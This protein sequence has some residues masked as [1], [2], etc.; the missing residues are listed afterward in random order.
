M[1]RAVASQ[2]AWPEP[3]FRINYGK[4]DLLPRQRDRE[5]LAYLIYQ[6]VAEPL[7]LVN[8]TRRIFLAHALADAEEVF[9]ALADLFIALGD[10]ATGLKHNLLTHCR[11]LLADDERL[12]LESALSTGFLPQDVRLPQKCCL[13]RKLRS[14]LRGEAFYS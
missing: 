10:K 7:N 11:D 9:A 14:S 1:Y 13:A 8:H 6:L 3:E 5:M 4:H 2:V 12:W